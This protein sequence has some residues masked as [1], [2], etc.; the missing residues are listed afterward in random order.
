MSGHAVLVWRYLP[1][2]TMK[3]GGG[4]KSLPVCSKVI[5]SRVSTQVDVGL[6]PCARNTDIEMVVLH[7][8]KKLYLGKVIGLA[9]YSSTA[10]DDGSIRDPL[11]WSDFIFLL[12]LTRIR[13][14]VPGDLPNRSTLILFADSPLEQTSTPSTPQNTSHPRTLWPDTLLSSIPIPK[15]SSSQP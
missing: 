11:G 8:I 9:R 14:S 5:C 12:T 15:Y 6:D 2:L 13:L 3:T 4:R 10:R 1:S 7:V